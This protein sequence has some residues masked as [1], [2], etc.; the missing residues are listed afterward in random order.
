MFYHYTRETWGESKAKP[1]YYDLPTPDRRQDTHRVQTNT[2]RFRYITE[3][4]SQMPLF[5]YEGGGI[6]YTVNL[7][8]KPVDI[9]KQNII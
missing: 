5:L 3:D 2:F 1:Q 6:C 9:S 7:S 8:C 4:N